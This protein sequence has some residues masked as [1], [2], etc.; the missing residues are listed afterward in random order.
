MQQSSR[1][2]T[3]RPRDQSES[4]GQA[5]QSVKRSQKLTRP[6]APAPRTAGR[7]SP[8]AKRRLYRFTPRCLQDGTYKTVYCT[9][10]PS[11]AHNGTAAHFKIGSGW[12]ES[13]V[14][15]GTLRVPV[16]PSS[17]LGFWIVA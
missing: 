10:A 1:P 15:G 5:Q 3:S 6:I 7:H 16:T 9:K 8:T 17:P 14:P 11:A 13:P 12:S 2:E 4:L